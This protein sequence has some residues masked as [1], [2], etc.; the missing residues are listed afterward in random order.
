[1][2]WPERGFRLIARRRAGAWPFLVPM[3]LLQRRSDGPVAVPLRLRALARRA[4]VDVEVGDES[5]GA[6]GGRHRGLIL[7]SERLRI[8]PARH[9]VGFLHTLGAPLR[10]PEPG[11][12][13]AGLATVGAGAAQLQWRPPGRMAQL[14]RAQPSHG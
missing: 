13:G 12:A 1:M 2:T 8:Y 11:V 6:L 14:V 4:S 9:P 7:S 3:R 5:L 10:P